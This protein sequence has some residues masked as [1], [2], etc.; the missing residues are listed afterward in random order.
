MTAAYEKGTGP[1]PSALLCD[2]DGVLRHFTDFPVT[3]PGSKVFSAFH[4]MPC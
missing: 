1:E 4:E 2:L 3:S